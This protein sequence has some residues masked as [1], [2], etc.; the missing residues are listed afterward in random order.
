MKF[1]IMLRAKKKV[2]S[3]DLIFK[4]YSNINFFSESCSQTLS[5]YNI[6]VNLLVLFC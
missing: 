4:I 5:F 1:D 6:I 3:N 2:Q